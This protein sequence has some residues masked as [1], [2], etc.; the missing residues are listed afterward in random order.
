MVA[1]G[2]AVPTIVVDCLFLS[3]VAL[4]IGIPVAR[5]RNW[6]NLPV[7]AVPVLLGGV[8]LLFHLD[9]LGA[10]LRV[11]GALIGAAAEPHA[12]AASAVLWSGA[13]ALFLAAYWPALTRPRVDAPRSQGL[14]GC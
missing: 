9:H 5:A 11:F 1:T 14:T 3:C 2:P 12:L 8:N 7:A 4:A 6:R 13:F 10:A